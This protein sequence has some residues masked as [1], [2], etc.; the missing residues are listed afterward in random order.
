MRTNIIVCIVAI[1]GLF[2][3]WE[4]N[5][6]GKDCYQY[7]G[8]NFNIAWAGYDEQENYLRL[9]FSPTVPVSND[10]PSLER[11]IEVYIPNGGLGINFNLRYNRIEADGRS[12]E[13]LVYF[14][15]RIIGV[16]FEGREEIVDTDNIISGSM[17]VTQNGEHSYNVYLSA[18][19]TNGKS[20]MLNFDG[21]FEDATAILEQPNGT[22]RMQLENYDERRPII[23]GGF[24]DGDGMTTITLCHTAPVRNAKISTMM[25]GVFI[26]DIPDIHMNTTIYFNSGGGL[27]IDE[28]RGPWR[29]RYNGHNSSQI[30]Y[31]CEAGGGYQNN[32]LGGNITVYRTEGTNSFSVIMNT[33]FDDFSY[34]VGE[35]EGELVDIVGLDVPLT[36]W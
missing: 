30:R 16:S 2:V 23:W 31:G 1:V 11:R 29:F 10:V 13:W 34:L 25:G 12:M 35:W 24:V 7:D 17:R 28:D 9:I 33:Q 8:K 20:L 27:N 3:S 18:K 36:M 26:M 21:V 15:D 6:N 19:F 5:R 4:G 32:V 14:M 22:G